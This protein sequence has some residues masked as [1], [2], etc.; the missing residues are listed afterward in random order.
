MEKENK[1]NNNNND[2][3]K[4][5]IA[6][7]FLIVLVILALLFAK[8]NVAPKNEL[9][10]EDDKKIEAED[11]TTEAS[12]EYIDVPGYS[13]LQVTS[14]KK[15]VR[16]INPEDNTVYFVYQ[17]NSDNGKMIYKTKAIKP[18]NMVE[19]DL[20]SILSS[21]DHTVNIVVNTYDVDT[22]EVCNGTTQQVMINV[23]K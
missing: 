13:N 7:I 10:F 20:Y 6:I 4:N 19:V 8:R 22:Q 5:I 16:L 15:T 21:G 17:I 3:K 9:D 2:K 12:T 1:N 23:V 18:G 14:E 11:N